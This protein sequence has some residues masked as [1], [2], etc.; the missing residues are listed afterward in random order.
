MTTLVLE[1]LQHA[2]SVSPDLTVSP[3]GNI[4]IGTANPST[5]SSGYDGG[6]LHIHNDG[7]GSSI[8]LTNSTTGTGT[9][10]GML[11]SKWNDSKTYFT[12]FDNGANTVFTQSNSSGTLITTLV[13][14]G[15]GKV[16]IGTSTPSSKLEVYGASPGATM[17]VNHNYA[18]TAANLSEFSNSP[19]VINSRTGGAQ[20]RTS[21]STTDVRLQAIDG[22]VTTAKDLLL[23]PF[24]GK[25]SVGGSASTITSKFTVGNPATAH[26][27]GY[28]ENMAQIY[29][30]ADGSTYDGRHYLN[31]FHD[32]NNRDSSGDP[33]VWGMAF[34]YD[35]NTR[36]GIQYDHKGIERM[37]LWSSYGDMHFKVGPRSANLKAHEISNSAMEITH[38]GEILKP[39]NPAF[40][41]Y[42]NQSSWVV[43]A[44]SVFVFNNTVH[45]RGGHYNTSNGRFTAPK[46]GIYQFNFHT[47]YT[48]NAGNDW[49]SIRRNGARING[50][51]FHFSTDPGSS[52]DTI[53]GALNL[54]LNSG[55]YI[56]MYAGTEHTYHGGNWSNFSG[57]LVG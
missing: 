25:V 19:F 56:E 17:Y 22:G 53:G 5:T 42:R 7:T 28:Q 49:I 40:Q 55:D 26:T 54:Y 27:P 20:L 31:F 57:Y 15:D 46:D 14:D 47:I 38:D 51:D 39:L 11:I 6:S 35:N 50:G 3:T 10:E 43:S 37:T 21:G 13:M 44:S 34:G 16:G 29:A 8:R 33:T 4:G 2:N 52:W 41:A 24:G 23:N 48:T 18:W 45:N 12:N 9:S 1:H 30:V 32:D 36:G